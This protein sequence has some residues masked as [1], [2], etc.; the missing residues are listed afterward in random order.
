[1]HWRHLLWSLCCPCTAPRVWLSPSTPAEHWNIAEPSGCQRGRK[2]FVRLSESKGGSLSLMLHQP[3]SSHPMAATTT[4]QTCLSSRHRPHLR[5]RHFLYRETPSLNNL[6]FQMYEMCW[7]TDLS[8][9]WCHFSAVNC[10]QRWC[11]Q[12]PFGRAEPLAQ[13]R[14]SHRLPKFLLSGSLEAVIGPH[15][16][17]ATGSTFLEL[18]DST[19]TMI[20]WA[21]S[22]E[23]CLFAKEA[24]QRTI[25]V[26]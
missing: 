3:R 10:Q 5:Y 12:V 24:C 22:A 7:K 20:L 8:P 26:C 25:A 23:A 2:T 14:E 15:H 11:S 18:Y 19:K 1:M 16:S 4:H 9:Q 17:T 6:F 21:T 13:V